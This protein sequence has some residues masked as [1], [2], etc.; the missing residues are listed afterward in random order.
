[1]YASVRKYGADA[2]RIGEL[3]HSI[4]EKFAPRLEEMPGFIAYQAIDAG[5]DRGGE[6]LVFTITLCSDQDAAERSAELA[7]EFVRDEL[8]DMKIERI[9]AATGAVSVSRA[10]SEV[11]DNAHA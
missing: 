4:D 8:G 11:L 2:D 7:A 5:V 1:M 10:V 6:G 3:M 9:E